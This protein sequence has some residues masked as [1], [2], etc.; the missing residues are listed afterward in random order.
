MKQE[1]GEQCLWFGKDNGTDHIV[2]QVDDLHVSSK[3]KWYKEFIEYLKKTGF[4]IK[5]MGLAA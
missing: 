3:E 2:V 4:N 1:P 5:D